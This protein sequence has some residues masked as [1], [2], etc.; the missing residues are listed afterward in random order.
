MPITTIEL[1]QKL[2]SFYGPQNWW[3][4]EGFE[5]VIGAILTQNTSW[6][7]V[8][9]ALDNLRAEGLLTPQGII[10]ASDERISQL[11][12]PSGY[13]NQKTQYLKNI[14]KLWLENPNPT[15]RELLDVKG[16]G[17][18][19]ADSILLYLLEKPEFVIDLYTVR[20]SQRLGLGASADKRYWKKFYQDSL[21]KDVK[22]FNEYHALIVEHAKTFCKKNN[23][24]CSDCFL[25]DNCNFGKEIE[26][27]SKL[28]P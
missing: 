1:Y 5:I 20:I 11:I 16:I 10:N 6:T 28:N 7:N 3:P 17:E 18:E 19:T 22:M 25:L 26:I 27:Q 2:F 13:F 14:S 4:G 9:N 21:K 24:K 15:R 8:E 12:Q 23:P